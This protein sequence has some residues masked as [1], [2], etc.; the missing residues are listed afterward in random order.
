[1]AAYKRTIFVINPKFQYKFSLMMCSIVFIGS[2]IYPFTIYE[3]YEKIIAMQPQNAMELESNR[4]YLLMLLASMEFAFLG[5]V[6]VICIFLS[7]KI[8]GPMYKLQ[9][10]LKN[11]RETGDVHPVFF[12]NGDNFH[13]IADEVNHLV[14]HLSAQREDD[15]AYLEE[16]ASYINNLALVV[17][18]DKKPIIKEILSRLATI[19][20]R[21][22]S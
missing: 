7:H 19:Q 10:H 6:F 16:V 8:A 15:F 4:S 1:M 17:P 5:I 13:E 3:L 12:R 14:E 11:L 21:L 22:Q 9:N 2:L 20:N 18:E